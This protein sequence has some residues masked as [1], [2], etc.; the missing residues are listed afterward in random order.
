LTDS[1][2]WKKASKGVKLSADEIM[3]IAEGGEAIYMPEAPSFSIKRG[4]H[5]FGPESETDHNLDKMFQTRKV[6]IRA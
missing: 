4:I 3:K 2:K 5:I 1:G 6:K